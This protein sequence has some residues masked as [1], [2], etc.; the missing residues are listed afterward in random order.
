MDASIIDTAAM[1]WTKFFG[2]GLVRK[3]IGRPAEGLPFGIRLLRYEAGA[4]API[5]IHAASAETIYVIAGQA[6][7]THGE[8][9][10]EVKAGALIVTPPG[11]KHGLRNI[12]SEPLHVLAIFSPPV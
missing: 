6:L 2:E 1:E 4:A 10:T 5:H 11:V 12:G 7:V 3:E 8:S 9:Q